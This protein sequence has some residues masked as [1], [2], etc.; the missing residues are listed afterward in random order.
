MSNLII[1]KGYKS[2]LNL[3]E[4]QKAIKLIKDFFEKNLAKTLHLTRVSA[5]LFVQSNSGLNDNLTGSEE[6]VHF[7]V[8]N[9][10]S[11][12]NLEIVHSLAKWKRN[13]LKEYNI[14]IGNGIYAD[15]NAIRAC[16]ISDNTHSFYVDQWDWEKAISPEDRN[17]KYLI[18]TV[19]DIY[20]ILLNTQDMLVKHY[21]KY[22]PIL[23]DQLNI[24]TTQELEDLFPSLSPEEREREYCKENGSM[25]LIGIGGK[26]NSGYPHDLRSPDYDDWNLNGDIIV[27]NPILDDALELSSMG[28]RVNSEVLNNQLKLSNTLDR[29]ELDFHKNL[30]NKLYPDAIGGGIGQSRLCMFFLQKAHIG[31]V[32]AS[33]WPENM[34]KECKE[35]KI[36]LL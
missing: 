27:W 33:I 11:N 19:R 35:N 4:T 34:I 25:F 32:Q 22:K 16:E 5:P 21:P 24:I 15:M 28:V 36:E 7:K 6:P 9:G 20:Q 10:K 29:L 12:M 18:S 26:L 30:I 1:P 14:P 8:R 13:A 17:I 31:E 3:L 2:D 23:K